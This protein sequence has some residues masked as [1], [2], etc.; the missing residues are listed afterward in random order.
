MAGAS[1]QRFRLRIGVDVLGR[2]T[3]TQCAPIRMRSYIRRR[4]PFVVAV[5]VFIRN[6]TSGGLRV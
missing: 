6:K 2:C 5:V 1:H 4:A 3:E